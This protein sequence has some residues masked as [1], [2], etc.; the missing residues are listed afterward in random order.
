[1]NRVSYIIM[2]VVLMTLYSCASVDRELN[3]TLVIKRK[4]IDRFYA[5]MEQ[6]APETK[7]FA[8]EKMRVLWNSGDMISIFNQSTYNSQYAFSGEDGDN[9]G[10]FNEISG[11]EFHSG[12]PLSNIYAVYPYSDNNNIE[13]D[14]NL[15]TLYL[16]SEQMYQAHSFGVEAN[17]MVAVSDNHY[18]AFKNLGGYL[19]LRLYGKKVRVSSIT[20]RGNNGEKISGK[21]SVAASMGTSPTVTMDASAHDAIKLICDPPV[22]LGI[23]AQQYTD[24]WFVIPP[25]SLKNGFTVTITDELG[26]VFQKTT[27]SSLTIFRSTVEWMGALEV[28]P[29]YDDV[30]IFIP[31]ANFK[32]YCVENFDTNND[33]EISVSEVKQVKKIIVNT[34][35]I[36]SLQGVEYFTNL[37]S[38]ICI[39]T[40]TNNVVK[41]K[42]ASLDISN[43]KALEIL[44]CDNNQLTTL[45]VSENANLNTLSCKGNPSLT[46]IWLNKGQTIFNLEYDTG[47]AAIKY[48]TSLYSF[49]KAYAIPEH[50]PGDLVDVYKAQF[51]IFGYARQVSFNRYWSNQSDSLIINIEPTD[52]ETFRYI[53]DT[54]WNGNQASEDLLKM[55]TGLHTVYEDF[56]RAYL[57]DFDANEIK[58][59]LAILRAY[60]SKVRNEYDSILSILENAP[61]GQGKIL[62]D[63]WAETV[64]KAGKEIREFAAKVDRYVN[65]DDMPEDNI[66]IYEDKVFHKVSYGPRLCIGYDYSGRIISQATDNPSHFILDTPSMP[67]FDGVIA[68]PLTIAPTKADSILVFNAVKDYFATIATINEKAVPYLKYITTV[69]PGSFRVDSVRAD[70]I[71]FAGLQM[72]R[73]D[74]YLDG[75][76]IHRSAAYDNK[77]IDDLT[78][79]P[80]V[81]KYVDAFTNL[82]QLFNHYIHGDALTSPFYNATDATYFAATAGV[83]EYV[84][85]VKDFKSDNTKSE[86]GT[87]M[88]VFDG[89]SAADFTK[90]TNMS[91]E[92]KALANWMD[93]CQKYFGVE[94]FAG[95]GEKVFFNYETFTEPTNV[96]VFDGIPNYYKDPKKGV[97]GIGRVDVVYFWSYQ[98]SF[99]AQKIQENIDKYSSIYTGYTAQNYVGW[100][101]FGGERYTDL[102]MKSKVFEL[103]EVEYLAYLAANEKTPGEA[104]E[105][106]GVVL[107]QVKADLD[108]V[109][110]D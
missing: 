86:L 100:N 77:G 12:N 51:G 17:A 52:K 16:P 68:H 53:V 74:A 78:V 44:E 33:G 34:N 89:Y 66:Y 45:D 75:R 6:S 55:K 61:E 107:S 25:V 37:K 71:D 13:N 21:A 41:G 70:K 10:S 8:D 43:N 4:N 81:N 49:K 104:W 82:M 28:I 67:W 39:G 87:F 105:E 63:A 31:D 24:F 18:L 58:P 40:A 91:D 83:V 46:E 62:C 93:A 23:S 99:V 5:I 32:A 90:Y 84:Q 42:L 60:A 57:F 47:V 72:K 109:T 73:T 1:M 97:T 7:V 101:Y 22:Q 15:I 64:E 2:V 102:V 76:G 65:Y 54:I 9:A 110:N 36:T 85:Y 94:G 27:N 26:G 92:G 106:L 48:K 11:G 79:P 30:N 35:N 3:D 95:I 96:V 108:A 50:W 14:G 69:Y 29:N 59:D 80:A 38:L 88:K 19:Q 103:L 20:I 56:S 98:Y